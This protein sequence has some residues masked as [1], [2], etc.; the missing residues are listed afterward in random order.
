M[1][2]LGTYASRLSGTGAAVV[3][4]FLVAAFW[5]N[6]RPDRVEG[7][8]AGQRWFANFSLFALYQGPW[9]WLAPLLYAATGPWSLHIPYPRA[10][11]LRF[12]I[13]V[14]ALD[15]ATYGLHR[16]FHAYGWLWRFHAVHHT[17]TDLDIS[18]TVRHHPIEALAMAVVLAGSGAIMG[19]T[20]AEIAAYGMIAFAVQLVAHANVA[21]PPRIAS[22]LAWVVVTPAYHRF[23]HA[24]EER[25][26]NAN[27][28]EVFLIWDRIFGTLAAPSQAIAVPTQFGVVAYLAPRFRSLGWML[29]QPFLPRPGVSVPERAAAAE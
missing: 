13:L 12:L 2:W 15:V 5:E 20:P 29:V 24:R 14:L 3:L 4:W 7:A 21:L 8:A 9:V 18:T 17:D 27:Y 23:H 28:G 11:G 16:L 6:R 10:L 26:S 25:F 19:A 22:A 1:D